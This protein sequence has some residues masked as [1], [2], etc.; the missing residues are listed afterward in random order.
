MPKNTDIDPYR[1]K[2]HE[3]AG[4]VR[5]GEE[6]LGVCE[7]CSPFTLGAEAPGGTNVPRSSTLD[8]QTWV[9]RC[10]ALKIL[11]RHKLTIHDAKIKGLVLVDIASGDVRNGL[12][13][14]RELACYLDEEIA[15]WHAKRW[16]PGAIVYLK[17]LE[18]C[19]KEIDAPIKNLEETIPRNARADG[20]MIRHCLSYGR[21]NG[22]PPRVV[23][24]VIFLQ[25]M[26]PGDLAHVIHRVEM[27]ARRTKKG[28]QPP[29]K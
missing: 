6:C 23:A 27:M 20:I 12:K 22:I 21:R 29:K 28:T 3:L 16:E 18:H 4:L 19:R 24:A 25:R 13:L 15:E 7:W 14:L 8:P 9:D 2:F 10:Q 26:L 1:T 17:N 11:H 5:K